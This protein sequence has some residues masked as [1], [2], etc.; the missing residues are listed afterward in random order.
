MIQREACL[1]HAC[2]HTISKK[3]KCERREESVQ[4]NKKRRKKSRYTHLCKNTKH[5]I[6]QIEENN[7]VERIY[8]FKI[9]FKMTSQFESSHCS[10]IPSAYSIDPSTTNQNNLCA[11]TY[12]L[13]ST[14]FLLLTCSLSTAEHGHNQHHI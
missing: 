7:Y 11:Y 12:S 14:T 8:I 4:Q 10:H 3:I 1:Q 13:N 2:I 9:L 5:R 6:D